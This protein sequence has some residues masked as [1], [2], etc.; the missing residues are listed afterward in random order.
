MKREDANLWRGWYQRHGGEIEFLGDTFGRGDV[1]SAMLL[2][3]F[4]GLMWKMAMPVS[5]ASR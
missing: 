1:T 5:H 3:L 4:V 2:L